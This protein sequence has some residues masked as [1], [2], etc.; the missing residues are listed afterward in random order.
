MKLKQTILVLLSLIHFAL[1]GTAQQN[2][3]SIADIAKMNLDEKRQ[4]FNT[5]MT[6]KLDDPSRLLDFY[7][8]GIK[9]PDTITQRKAVQNL[10]WVVLSFQEMRRKGTPIPMDFSRLGE[11]QQELGAMLVSPDAEMRGAAIHALV[12]TGLRTKV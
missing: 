12:F 5:P 3:F 1:R 8:I 9:D 2:P 10:A 4:L 11:L 6:R 7:L